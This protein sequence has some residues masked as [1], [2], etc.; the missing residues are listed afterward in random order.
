MSVKNILAVYSG[1]VSRKSPLI[2]ALKLAKLHD[3]WISGAI[4]RYG[5]SVAESRFRGR[6]PTTIIEEIHRADEEYQNEIQASYEGVV[7][8]AGML[9]RSEFHRIDESNEYNLSA[10]ARSFDLIVMGPHSDEERDSHLSAYPDRVALQSGRPVL[11]VP[12]GY[13]SEGLADHALVAW[14]GKRS[15][16]RALGDAMPYLESKSKVTILCV[17]KK[18][19][20][21]TDQLVKSLTRHGIATEV[22]VKPAEHGI[23]STISDT[24]NKVGAKLIV[25]GAFEHSKFA[26]D[27][28]GGVTNQVMADCN[29]PVFL[30]H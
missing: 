12:N 20:E 26:Q 17:G 29:V 30:A 5:D 18:A 11:I 23:S 16:A 1:K 7:K 2:H 27:I 3:A 10:F 4:S 21:G 15:A 9:D 13:E 14:D 22:V 6:I 28:F 19:P 24:V 25:M 8:E